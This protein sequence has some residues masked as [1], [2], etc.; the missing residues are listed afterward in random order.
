MSNKFIEFRDINVFSKNNEIVLF[1]RGN[2]ADKTMRKLGVK[3]AFI[4]DNNENSWNTFE[5]DLKVYAPSELAKY[6]NKNIFILICTTSFGEVSSQLESM[7][8]SSGKHFAVT[9]ILN[10][11]RV[12]DEIESVE[13]NLLFTSGSAAQDSPRF[14]GG[15]Y[16]LN[17][18]N[19]VWD[20]KKVFS[21]NSHGLIR[22]GENFIFTNDEMG[23]VEMDS[24]YKIIRTGE[25]PA[26]SRPHGVAYCKELERFYV[27]GSCI[28]AIM[29]FDKDFKPINQI[30]LSSKFD[31]L[32][33]P[34][35]HM[36]DICISG[37][38]LY[39][40]MFSVTGNWK[41][42]IFDGVVLEV[43][44]ETD[45]VISPVI[46][47]LWM[48][49]NVEIVDGSLTVLDSLRGEF[50]KGNA[51]PIGKFPG[52]TRGLGYDG[53]FYYIGQ[54]RNRNYSKYMG[55]SQNISIDASIIIFDEKTKVSK[56]LFLPHQISEIHSI[57]VIG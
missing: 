43:N 56:S 54:S 50:K 29:V 40:S 27:A 49:H 55:L 21:G 7:G 25:V 11:L 6:V 16:E 37:K 51:Q 34:S 3:P 10:D 30:K 2:I 12:I 31:A 53:Y 46:T 33:S 5:Q 1:G 4:V 36:N 8:F 26:G 32:K 45:T 14:G 24:N 39:A 38:T 22:F 57:R 48:P 35:H 28:D 42:D 13:V 41:K 44:L 52:F 20:Y 19:G 17:L 23:I 18:K 15:I 9:P 47:D